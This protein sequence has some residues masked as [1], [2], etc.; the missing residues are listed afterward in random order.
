MPRTE[1]ART[2]T[3]TAATMTRTRPRPGL[4][5]RSLRPGFRRPP[6]GGRSGWGRMGREPPGRP[7]LPG[8]AWYPEHP[9]PTESGRGRDDRDDEAPAT[10]VRGRHHRPRRERLTLRDRARERVVIAVG[11]GVLAVIDQPPEG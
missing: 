9:Q 11:T 4:R 2:N 3:T 5:S 6:L 7:V 10:G 1:M 8:R